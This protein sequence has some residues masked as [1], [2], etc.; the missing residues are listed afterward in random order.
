VTSHVPKS[1]VEA[2]NEVPAPQLQFHSLP[3]GG[4]TGTRFHGHGVGID[5]VDVINL[6]RYFHRVNDGLEE[7]LKNQHAPLVL[8]CV[9]YLA[10]L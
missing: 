4:P 3:V 6:Q 2:L 5:D 9:E 10:P 7:M 1:L 8:A